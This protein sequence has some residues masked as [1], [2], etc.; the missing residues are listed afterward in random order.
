MRNDAWI[1]STFARLRLLSS[2][3]IAGEKDLPTN[4]QK[5]NQKEKE[6][7]FFIATK[8]SSWQ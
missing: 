5:F 2:R 3:E 1:L 6:I 7:P 4:K 8:T